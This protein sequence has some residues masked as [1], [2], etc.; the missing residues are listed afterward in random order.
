MSEDR[1]PLPQLGPKG[2]PKWMDLPP[3]PPKPPAPTF[4]LP[5]PAEKLRMTILAAIDELA[6]KALEKVPDR[7]LEAFEDALERVIE[8][9]LEAER[10]T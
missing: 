8:T 6:P 5:S 1:K 2:R 3:L 7:I 9:A 10:K 4:A